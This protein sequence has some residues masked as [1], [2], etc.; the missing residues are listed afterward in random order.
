MTPPP[1]S[2]AAAAAPAVHYDNGVLTRGDERFAVGEADDIVVVGRWGCSV[3]ETVALVQR[4][5]GA[6]YVF[7]EWPESGVEVTAHAVG[8]VDGAVTA[9]AEDADGDGCHDLV[10]QRSTG[11]RVV[12]HPETAR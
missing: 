11:E 4:T 3:E 9:R 6:V 7:H 5:S 10:V 1:S 2:P 12:L 8:A